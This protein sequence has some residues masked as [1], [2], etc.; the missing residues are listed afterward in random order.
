MTGKPGVLLSMGLQ[1]AGHD[2]LKSL[3]NNNN[4]TSLLIAVKTPDW[5]KGIYQEKK[6]YRETDF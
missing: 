3:N 5:H 4:R 1:R 6:E 2:I